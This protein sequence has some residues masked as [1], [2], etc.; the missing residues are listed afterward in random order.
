METENLLQDSD[1]EDADL[2]DK[3]LGRKDDKT[4]LNQIQDTFLREENPVNEDDSNALLRRLQEE[5]ALESKYSSFEKQRD[6]NLEKRYLALRQGSPSSV[7]RTS[8][9]FS[10]TPLG[11]PPKP[12]Q[13]DELYDETEDWCCKNLPFDIWTEKGK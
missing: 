5:V 11:R 13:P 1:E 3:I 12:I 7:A 10:S 6:Q 4:K 2:L 9:E 8:K